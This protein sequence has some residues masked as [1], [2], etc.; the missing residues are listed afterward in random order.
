[1]APVRVLAAA[2]LAAK[3]S[4]ERAVVGCS[5]AALRQRTVGD[6]DHPHKPLLVHQA[7]HQVAVAPELL[8]RRRRRRRPRR[9]SRQSGAVT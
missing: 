4:L 9:A 5:R 7:V 6:E 2:H 8:R 3:R 1:M